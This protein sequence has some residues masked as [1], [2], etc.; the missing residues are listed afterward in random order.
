[1][2]NKK[3]NRPACRGLTLLEMIISLAIIAVVFAV[4]L[5]QFR[6]IQN[7]WASKQATAE[8][9]QNGRILTSYLHQNLAKAARITDVSDP[10]DITGYIEFEGN[11]AIT[12][13]CEI[14]ADN[15][16]E[17]GPVGNLADLA[18]PVGQMQFTCY[19]DQDLDNPITTVGDIRSVNV[20]ITLTNAGPGR[21]Q[22]FTTQ[23]YLRTNAT[24]AN[25]TLATEN[26][27]GLKEGDM[28]LCRIDSTHYFLADGRYTDY[29]LSVDADTGTVAIVSSYVITGASNSRN[30]PALCKIDDT[31][32]LKASTKGAQTAYAFVY[33][34]DPADWSIT[35]ETEYQYD[36]RC[37]W[38]ALAKIDDTHYLCLYEIST[39]GWACVLTVDPADWSVSSG[40]FFEF[41][42]NADMF[43]VAKIDDN[44]YLVTCRPSGNEAFV[45]TVES[46]TYAISK[47]TSTQIHP[48]GAYARSDIR[49]IDSNH[50]L[51]AYATNNDHRAVTLT[52][53]TGDWSVSTTGD[54]F[55]DSADE[56]CASIG[57]FDST[58][59]A[60]VYHST[61]NSPETG[62]GAWAVQ[63]TVDT[64]AWT[65]SK[66][67]RVGVPVIA[68]LMKHHPALSNIDEDR[69]LCAY[70]DNAKGYA[71]VIT[72]GGSAVLSP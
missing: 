24:L 32:I 70:D 42:Y 71:V 51:C 37:R 50:F 49:Q 26:V 12:Y 63:L 44:H 28:A 30:Y 53:D 3:N 34:V 47:G 43:S 35:E 61:R 33:S 57:S 9:I 20:R 29:V 65:I 72:K 21:D 4:I 56:L 52:I 10:C 58:D 38:P 18:G 6:N 67:T 16:V 36:S 1:M 64:E 48:N 31:H 45:M 17:F 22:T 8:A 19:D 46:G 54:V 14:G 60:C 27:L 13:R 25:L 11:D 5:P 7:S 68:G 69:V 62:D 41:N 23:A 59:F 39:K 66:G 40:S 2:Y 15:I 55:I